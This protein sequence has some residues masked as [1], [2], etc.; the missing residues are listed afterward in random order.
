MFH[1]FSFQIFQKML[2]EVEVWWV[3]KESHVSQQN[4]TEEME[5]NHIVQ[6]RKWFGKYNSSIKA[7]SVNHL[8]T[9][10]PRVELLS[11]FGSVS[12][13]KRL[14]CLKDVSLIHYSTDVGMNL[15]LLCLWLWRKT[16]GFWISLQPAEMWVE[17]QSFGARLQIHHRTIT[18]NVQYLSMLQE[19]ILDLQL[20]W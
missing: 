18:K 11:S 14:F 9:V 8:L 15:G 12:W 3:Q 6:P 20:D 17:I 2:S 13:I 7:A 19:R 4:F 5:C 16:T 10:L 1:L